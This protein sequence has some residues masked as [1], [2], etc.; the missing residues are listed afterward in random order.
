[1]HTGWKSMSRTRGTARVQ[2][3]VPLDLFSHL[4]GIR[5]EHLSTP[6]IV[7]QY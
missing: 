1:M 4:E 7:V 3:C 6:T 5:D 2:Q